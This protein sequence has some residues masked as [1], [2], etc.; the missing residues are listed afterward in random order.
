[1]EGIQTLKGS[2]P[3]PWPWIR[4]YGMPSCITHRPLY[5]YQIS[6]KLKKL[7]VDGRTDVRTDIFPPL[8]L[9]GWLLEVDLKTE[10]RPGLVALYDIR[11]GNGAGRFLQPRSPHGAQLLT[12]VW[13]RVSNWGYQNSA[14][15]ITYKTRMTGWWHK[16]VPKC[17]NCNSTP[18]CDRVILQQQPQPANLLYALHKNLHIRR[19][20]GILCRVGDAPIHCMNALVDRVRRKVRL[21]PSTANKRQ[22]VTVYSNNNRISTAPHG[23]NFRDSGSGPD[24]CSLKAWLNRK[25]S[26]LHSKTDGG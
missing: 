22:R 11:L 18:A 26:S 7:F 24:Q 6:L 23:R 12:I 15:F 4:S 10:T 20:V 5:I 21:K 3:W 16:P 1:M 19:S 8:I 9:L 2:W 25:V 17:V 14:T 13:S